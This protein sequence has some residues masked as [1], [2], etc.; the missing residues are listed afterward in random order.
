MTFNIQ[1]ASIINVEGHRT[2]KNCKAVYCITT[3][4]VYASVSD[5]AE[6][7]GVTPT[8]LGWALSGRSKSCKGKRFCFIN[9][10]VEH[11]DEIAENNRT[12]E[13][14]VT[15]YNTIVEKQDKIRKAQAKVDKH[16]SKVDEL[17]AKLDD[18]KRLMAEAESE[19]NELK[20]EEEQ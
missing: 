3:G 16:K 8:A 9:Q 5:A 19:L 18:A 11:L 12:R 10:I 14:K 17:Q 13:A 2:H 15:A 6:A 1:N 4:E 20:A 7:N